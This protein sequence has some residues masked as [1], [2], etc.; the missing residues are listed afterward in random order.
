MINATLAGLLSWWNASPRSVAGEGCG[1]GTAVQPRQIQPV[2]I[3]PLAGVLR[4]LHLVDVVFK[5]R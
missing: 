2:M 3:T 5:Y 4:F 1:A